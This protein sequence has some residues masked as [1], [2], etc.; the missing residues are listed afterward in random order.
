MLSFVLLAAFSLSGK[1][2]TPYKYIDPVSFILPR[3]VLDRIEQIFRQ[4]LW[5][6]P[7]LGSKGAK[8]VWEDICLPK[9]ERGL[10]I[11]RLCDCNT[12]AMLKHIRILL[13]NKEIPLV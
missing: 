9:E 13:T 4:F 8:V 12:V 3:M 11:R 7:G 2:S 5:K 1:H 6:G 10:G